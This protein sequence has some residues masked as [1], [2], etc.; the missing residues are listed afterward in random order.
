MNFVRVIDEELPLTDHLQAGT[1]RA[2]IFLHNQYLQFAIHSS[3]TAQK[4]NTSVS[5]Q[6]ISYKMNCPKCTHF[7][8]TLINTKCLHEPGDWCQDFSS[9]YSQNLQFEQILSRFWRGQFYS[10]HKVGL[11]LPIRAVEGMEARVILLIPGAVIKARVICVLI[12]KKVQI[13]QDHLKGHNNFG[14]LNDKLLTRYPSFHIIKKEQWI[15][16]G[17]ESGPEGR[18]RRRCR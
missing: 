15:V 9:Q 14:E 16:E 11:C 3:N 12:K 10:I 6:C 8:C 2:K 1:R 13:V 4:Y 18:W 17:P 7:L 5:V